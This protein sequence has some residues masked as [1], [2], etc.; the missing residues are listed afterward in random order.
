MRCR[1]PGVGAKPYRIWVQGQTP[2]KMFKVDP[3][4]VSYK[5]LETYKL[6][7]NGIR[8]LTGGVSPLGFR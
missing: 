1:D 3:L 7:E 4:Q 2:G 6:P 5:L 8:C